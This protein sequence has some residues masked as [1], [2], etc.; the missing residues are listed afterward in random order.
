MKF[1]LSTLK[2]LSVFLLFISC[3]RA[4]EDWDVLSQEEI[5][6]IILLVKEDVTGVVK[7]YNYTANAA[8]NPEIILENGKSYTVDVVFKNGNED[9]NEEIIEAKDEHFLVYQ[10]V[11]ASVDLVRLSGAEDVR[12][13]GNK[14]GLK[15]HWTVNNLQNESPKLV[16]TLHHAAISVSENK[17][18]T[19]YGT[20]EGGEV[21]AEAYYN[22][23]Y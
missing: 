21:D 17:N 8:Q 23:K 6:N 22:L 18:L 4:D 14:V 12:S 11:N 19:T 7:S 1:I 2:I 16:L 20:V 13:D 3:H 9:L 5:S 10:F 15:T